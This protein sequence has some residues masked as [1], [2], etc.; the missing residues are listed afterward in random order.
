MAVAIHWLN[1]DGMPHAAVCSIDRAKA[2]LKGL[3]F[4]PV[5]LSLQEHLSSNSQKLILKSNRS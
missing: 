5:P 2:A 1:V 4:H 3:L